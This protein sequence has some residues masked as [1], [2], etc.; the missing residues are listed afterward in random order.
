MLASNTVDG[1]MGRRPSDASEMRSES[2]RKSQGKG[3]KCEVACLAL[4]AS[5]PGSSGWGS[6]VI[7]AACLYPLLSGLGP[8][9][10]ANLLGYDVRVVFTNAL[11]Y[12]NDIVCL[13]L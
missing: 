10:L 2:A 4:L 3:I 13:A 7:P 11:S 12:H 5:I 1:R 8:R 9:P 6:P